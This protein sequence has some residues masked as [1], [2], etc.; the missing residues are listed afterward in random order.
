MNASSAGG[1]RAGDP[2]DIRRGLLLVLVAMVVLPGQDTVAKFL[3]ATVSP[4]TITWVRFL[5]QSLFMLPFL[6]Y[7]H[8]T[9]GLVPRRLGLNMV[10]GALV[11]CSSVLFFAAIKFMPLADAMA[12]FF[13]EP[14]ILT[15]LS[16]V[17]DKEPVGWRR[18]IAVAV[19][20]VGVLIVIQPSWSVFGAISIVPALSGGL[21]AVYVLLNRRV[22]MYD[23]PLTM[24]FAAGVSA[25]AVLTPVLFLGQLSG[26]SELMPTPPGGNELMLLLLMGVFGTSGH[27]LF[28]QAARSVP[29]SIIAP[30]QYAEIVCAALYGYLVFGDFPT[31]VKWFGIA[32]VVGSGAY[33]FWR[34]SRVRG[35]TPRP[36]SPV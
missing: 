10:R 13:I 12:I 15:I 36:P 9:A 6:L 30:M 29:S 23:A 2:G 14:F 16:A 31:L 18:R 4:G 3:S 21:F 27:L 1:A 35:P 28:V 20:F 32:I 33:V 11:A 22:S 34:E 5:L 26:A 8:G 24:Q 25:L 7:F 17:V 19:G